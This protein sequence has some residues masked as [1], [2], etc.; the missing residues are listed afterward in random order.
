ME[1]YRGKRCCGE[2]KEGERSQE[3]RGTARSCEVRQGE[4]KGV[5]GRLGKT[6]DE[7]GWRGW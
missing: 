4:E 7:V 5:K 1:G 2:A 6:R 3:S